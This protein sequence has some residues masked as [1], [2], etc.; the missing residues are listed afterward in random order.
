MTEPVNR[1]NKF[2]VEIGGETFESKIINY[3]LQSPAEPEPIAEAMI[4]TEAGHTYTLFGTWDGV[5]FMVQ[6]SY[7][8][9]DQLLEI[10]DTIKNWAI[11]NS[12]LLNK[13]YMYRLGVSLLNK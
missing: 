3:S 10:V 1:L 6:E 9:T 12:L 7:K 11:A 8:H 2:T 4:I 5:N 13:L